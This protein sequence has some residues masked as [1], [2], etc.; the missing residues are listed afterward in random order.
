MFALTL[1]GGFVSVLAVLAG[2]SEVLVDGE[3]A[4]AR[5]TGSEEGEPDND[6]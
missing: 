3:L 6:A 2:E 4:E 1:T 5:V